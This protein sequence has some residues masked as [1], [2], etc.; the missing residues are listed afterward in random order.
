MTRLRSKKKA[1]GQIK[2]KKGIE[3]K[4]MDWKR[5]ARGL[6]W[7]NSCAKKKEPKTEQK[8]CKKAEKEIYGNDRKKKKAKSK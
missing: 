2:R 3:R 1:R 5:M 7:R 8:R 6:F 4:E